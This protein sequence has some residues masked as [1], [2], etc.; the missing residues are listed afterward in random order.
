MFY[1]CPAIVNHFLFVHVSSSG[2]GKA[3]INNAFTLVTAHFAFRIS[4]KN[5]KRFL[6]YDLFV[7]IDKAT[8]FLCLHCDLFLVL[9]MLQPE[10]ITA[11]PNSRRQQ[12]LFQMAGATLNNE[13]SR[14]STC[15]WKRV[16]VRGGQ[17]HLTDGAG[18]TTINYPA[19]DMLFGDGHPFMLGWDGRC[20]VY[21]SWGMKETQCCTGLLFFTR[22]ASSLSAASTSH[23]KKDECALDGLFS[24]LKCLALHSADPVLQEDVWIS[25]CI[26]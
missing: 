2:W 4:E 12:C 20:L 1:L 26:H 8:H 5:V 25:R 11:S 17:G 18:R 19:Q 7:F 9:H 3:S 22:A 6:K 14:K 15:D 16:Y 23:S 10:Q 13:S 21:L 24:W